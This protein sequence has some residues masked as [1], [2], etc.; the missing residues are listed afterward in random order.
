MAEQPTTSPISDD[1]LDHALG[2]LTRAAERTR[3]ELE[4]TINRIHQAPENQDEVLDAVEPWDRLTDRIEALLKQMQAAG[5][6]RGE[7]YDGSKCPHCGSTDI[8]GHEIDPE[9]AD[10]AYRNVDCDECG[11]T[12]TEILAVIGCDNV[13]PPAPGTS[14]GPGS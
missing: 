6:Y 4:Q 11:A 1:L 9:G 12:W 14:G 10:K 2:D 5:H 7:P 3:T 8:S 13:Q